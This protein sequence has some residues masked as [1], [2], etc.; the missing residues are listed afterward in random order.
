M[1]VLKHD[2][3]TIFMT[4]IKFVHG[5]NILSLTKGNSVEHLHWV[6]SLLSGMCLDSQYWVGT[7]GQDE[8]EY[9]IR[10]YNSNLDGLLVISS[11]FSKINSLPIQNREKEPND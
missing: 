11:K 5:N 6:E 9:S 2:P 1:N 8:V 4:N 7:R 10:S 3:V